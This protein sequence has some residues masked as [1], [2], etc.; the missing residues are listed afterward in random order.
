MSPNGKELQISNPP[1]R[2][3]T[4]VNPDLSAVLARIGDFLG[5]E[6]SSTDSRVLAR[7]LADQ[8]SLLALIRESSVSI[9]K[10]N[11]FEVWGAL[12]STKKGNSSAKESCLPYN[13][14]SAV[15]ALNFDLLLINQ[16]TEGLDTLCLPSF[17]R[18]LARKAFPLRSGIHFSDATLVEKLVANPQLSEK[19]LATEKQILQ[20][21]FLQR[22]ELLKQT[23]KL[24]PGQTPELNFNTSQFF[25]GH[26]LH[27]ALLGEDPELPKMN[28]NDLLRLL[29]TVELELWSANFQARGEGFTHRIKT[30]LDKQTVPI[31]N[32]PD[33][34]LTVVE[35]PKPREP[36]PKSNLI[37]IKIQLP[38]SPLELSLNLDCVAKQDSPKGL[39][40]LVLGGTYL[41]SFS[42]EVRS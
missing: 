9:T 21:L 7:M 19:L 28:T 30:L 35:D 25:S 11:E 32:T 18:L 33:S 4:R 1:L 34:D 40:Y 8:L 17:R 42:S 27:L 6:A 3:L 39:V 38:G 14:A 36:N 31:F 2:S 23:L 26:K 5:P 29:L 41:G 24:E 37:P 20:K 15:E 10:M 12:E 13:L 22:V 16:S